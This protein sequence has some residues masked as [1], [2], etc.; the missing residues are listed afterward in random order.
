[1]KKGVGKIAIPIL[2]GLILTVCLIPNNVFAGV[3][4]SKEGS[5]LENISINWSQDFDDIEGSYSVDV[6][7]IRGDWKVYASES[8]EESLDDIFNKHDFLKLSRATLIPDGD[9]HTFTGNVTNGY[10]VFYAVLNN[11]LEYDKKVC[12]PST[13]KL[14]GDKIMFYKKNDQTK[15]GGTG[16]IQYKKI[17]TKTTSTNISNKKACQLMQRGIYSNSGEINPKKDC[18]GECLTKL[19]KFFPYCWGQESGIEFGNETINKIKKSFIDYYHTVEEFKAAAEKY[20]ES[21]EYRDLKSEGIEKKNVKLGQFTCEKD[22]KD[23]KEHVYWHEEET[24]SNKYCSVKCT[25]QLKVNYAPPSAVK[26]GLCFQY[27]VTV[28]SKVICKMDQKSTTDIDGPQ[29]PP[30]EY[31]VQCKDGDETAGPSDSFD[32][33]VKSCDGGKYSQKC[34]DKCYKSVYENSNDND[35]EKMSN[36]DNNVVVTL[37]GNSKVSN[38][39][40]YY[41][42]DG[43][44]FS[45]SNKCSTWENFKKNHKKCAEGFREAKA[46]DPKGHYQNNG[47][48]VYWIPDSDVTGSNVR[49][50]KVSDG[51]KC[52]VAKSIAR[53]AP[54][55]TASTADTIE[56]IASL[57]GYQYYKSN[58]SFG[59]YRVC[60][61]CYNKYKWYVIDNDGFSRQYGSNGWSCPDKCWNTSS[62]NCSS[63]SESSVRKEVVQK[64]EEEKEAIQKCTNEVEKSCSTTTATYTI[65]ANKPDEYNLGT[66]KPGNQASEITRGSGDK[67][68]AALDENDMENGVNGICY[69]IERPD[70][71]YKTTISFPD[72]YINRKTGDII[73]TKTNP[74]GCEGNSEDGTGT[75]LVKKFYYCT[76]YNIKSVNAK[77][78]EWKLLKKSEGTAPNPEKYNIHATVGYDK[79]DVEKG[80]FGK[81]GWKLKLDCFYAVYNCTDP[82]DP[83][84]P[85]IANRKVNDPECKGDGCTVLNNEVRTVD[86]KDPFNQNKNRTAAT[87]SGVKTSKREIGFN[88]TKDAQIKYDDKDLEQRGYKVNPEDY[89]KEIQ[90]IAEQGR[91]YD[92]SYVDFEITLDPEQLNELK[93]YA[94]EKTVNAFEG[95]Y[96]T[97][98][99]KKTLSVYT[100]TL[101][102]K[103]N[104]IKRSKTGYN[105]E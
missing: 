53:S 11:K 46:N 62:K 8:S 78:W 3:A 68:F 42:E 66:N 84:C 95:S 103:Y 19:R 58:D 31:G 52:S 69:G 14:N 6:K 71:H 73:N 9:S 2:F 54:Y 59:A 48:K 55:Y 97:I 37:L 28:K 41:D 64:T 82:S 26:A 36:I 92:D 91:T 10:L 51:G 34:I 99:D 101:L 44:A 5:C 96:R 65:G 83:N 35:I 27:Q 86:P 39:S 72:S 40:T 15:Q 105:N 90:S 57:F 56:L 100:S 75:C 80:G 61:T 33:C 70:W 47:K 38:Y 102:N 20:K 87:S 18:S 74:T 79:N 76:P 94:N 4:K 21:Q 67:I 16:L 25:E 60:S 7:S 93:K 98:G 50:C 89:L 77:W 23:T 45:L 32:Q 17:K 63:K 30:C 49:K 81:F 29:M 24:Y 12:N 104:P 13:I 88:W 22:Q 43:K 85:N 1:M